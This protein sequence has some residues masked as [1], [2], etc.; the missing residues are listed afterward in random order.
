MGN[1][2]VRGAKISHLLR[3]SKRIFG[4]FGVFLTRSF[5]SVHIDVLEGSPFR[6]Q[7]V[8]RHGESRSEP[9]HVSP[10]QF[11]WHIFPDPDY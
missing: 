1:S 7:A 3:R 4:L 8:P 5:F 6:T 10:W 2:L 11:F 9:A